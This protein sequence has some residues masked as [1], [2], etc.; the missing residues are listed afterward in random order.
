MPGVQKF[1]KE[2]KKL[3]KLKIIESGV[4][5]WI[6]LNRKIWEFPLPEYLN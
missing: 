5:K 2:Q 6:T 3:K 4:I 1:D